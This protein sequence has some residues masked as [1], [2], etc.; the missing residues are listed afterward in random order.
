MSIEDTR[1]YEKLGL[2]YVQIKFYG[3]PN[4]NR[5]VVSDSSVISNLA[6][7]KYCHSVTKVAVF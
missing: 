4:K 2:H 1:Y 7:D 6:G 3:V 5:L